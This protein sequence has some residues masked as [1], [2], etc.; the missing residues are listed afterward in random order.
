MVI[1]GTTG[2]VHGT[3]AGV[4]YVALPPAHGPTD[5]LVLLWHLVGHPG[6]PE[7]MATALPLRD[8]PAWRVYP[9]LPATTPPDTTGADPITDWYAPLVESSVA[10]VPTLLEHLRDR[11]GTAP[12]PVDL[13][14]GSA[15][16]HIA[17]LTAARRLTPVRRIAVINP[18]VTAEAVVDASTAHH[19][20]HHDWTP[21]ARDAARDLDVLAHAPHWPAPL[22][23]VRGDQEYPA[24]RPVQDALHT[25]VPGSR[26]VQVPGLAHML[27]SHTDLV[28]AEVTAWLA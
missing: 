19:G 11:L 9:A 2:T 3:A 24:F 15:G 17:L 1:K 14:G 7:D 13:V 18:A 12:A 4:R 21:A 8:V 16:G 5:R 28:D 10:A 20:L 26:L 25:A 6:T 27:V 23:L 22:L